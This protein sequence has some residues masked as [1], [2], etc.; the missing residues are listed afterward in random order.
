MSRTGR[1]RRG[2]AIETS[3]LPRSSTTT[4]WTPSLL[5]RGQKCA[6]IVHG[7]PLAINAGDY[8]LGLVC[9]I[10]VRDPGLEDA[11]KLAVLDVIGEM[12]ARTVEGQALDVGW[13][14]DQIYDLTPADYLDMALG[15]TGYY[16]GI[17]PLKVGALIGGGTAR[18]MEALHEFGKASSI[19]FQIQDDLLNILGDV[20][21]MGK[22]YLT[23]IVESKRTLMVIHCLSVAE[24]GDRRH[25]VES[26]TSGTR[27]DP[28]AGGRS[29]GLAQQVR[30]PGLRAHYGAPVDPQGPALPRSDPGHPC[31]RSARFHGGFLPGKGEM[32]DDA[33]RQA[34]RA[35]PAVEEVLN[36][37]ESARL[38]EQ[39]PR[40]QVV[41]AVRLA[42]EAARRR[43]MGGAADPAAGA[44]DARAAVTS[45]APEDL[46]ADAA[47]V[48]QGW[49]LPGLRRLLNLTGVVIHTNL[50][51]APLSQEAVEQVTQVA[52]S[53]SNL[54]YDLETGV[55]GSRET[56]VEA[57][58]T[59][60]TGGEAAFA[61]N[62]NAGAVLLLLMTLASGRE[63]LVS[64]GQLVEIGGSFR[65]PDIMRAG[66]V[67]LIEVGTT[68]RTRIADYEAAITAE[69]ALIL[70]VH[71]S[72]Y[73]I[74]GFTEE[75]DLGELVELGR[76]RGVPVADDLGSGACTTSTP[77][78][79]SLPSP[80]RCAPESMSC[81]S[82]ETNCSEVHKP[83]SSWAGGRSSSA[84]GSIRS[85]GRCAWTR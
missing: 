14:R 52:R 81:A 9:T 8:A 70:R 34:L 16:S 63:V 23:D 69:T 2:C 79:A 18:E 26:A 45:A 33:T 60:L 66:G 57:L 71:T 40:T 56:Y 64:R 38:L 31:P 11:T 53:Y 25:L 76:R 68:N 48:L 30:L 20:D 42:L 1:C 82:A 61:V 77:S 44:A 67:R 74:M 80:P 10:V 78:E 50:G 49:A 13:V 84:C 28:G 3:T 15:K 22:D 29:R 19:A 5:R 58:L 59:R 21:T 83:A 47:A 24:P 85:L 4:S 46:L 43:I 41:E 32:M 51:R 17:A 6:H 55:R 75:A 12:S 27:Q 35:L 54:E 37:P 65:L 7:E 73:R 36:R 72:N 39:Y 62:N